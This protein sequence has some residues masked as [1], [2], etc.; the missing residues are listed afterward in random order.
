[1]PELFAPVA[2]HP[3]DELTPDPVIAAGWDAYLADLEPSLDSVA[4]DLEHLAVYHYE[5]GYYY[6][7]EHRCPLT[8]GSEVF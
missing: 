4:G 8:V 3:V 6:G 2:D 7:T 1:M 5:D